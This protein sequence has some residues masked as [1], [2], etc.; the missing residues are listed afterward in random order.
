VPIACDT[1]RLMVGRPGPVVTSLAMLGKE[2]FERIQMAAKSLCSDGTEGAGI[3]FPLSGGRRMILRRMIGDSE[4][5]GL[6]TRE[7]YAAGDA[8]RLLA[9][10]PFW[11]SASFTARRT[12]QAPMEP[13]GA[14]D[15]WV[16]AMRRVPKGFVAL[17]AGDT[18]AARD[19]HQVASRPV[20]TPTAS[21]ASTNAL[22]RE[23][24]PSWVLYACVASTAASILFITTMLSVAWARSSEAAAPL[25]LA[26]PR[27]TT[28]P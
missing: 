12:I 25:P 26:P 18:P 21:V 17:G 15:R 28:T 6:V 19:G 4:I 24:A 10:D 1:L 5:R 27:P 22:E 3:G 9:S 16:H 23:P 14:P 11:A 13:G 2:D 8:L 20:S 7:G